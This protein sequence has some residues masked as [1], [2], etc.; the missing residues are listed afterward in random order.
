MAEDLKVKAG[1]LAKQIAALESEFQQF[2]LSQVV[3][4]FSSGDCTNACTDA[5]TRGCTNGCTGSGCLASELIRE[6]EVSG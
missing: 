6:E 1:D 2:R 4:A 5:C 3:A